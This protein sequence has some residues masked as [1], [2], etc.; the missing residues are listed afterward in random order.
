M[1][2]L[3]KPWDDVGQ[4]C[5]VCSKHM[6]T[7]T[8]DKHSIGLEHVLEMLSSC[9]FCNGKPCAWL[10][11]VALRYTDVQ[12]VCFIAQKGSTWFNCAIGNDMLWST[13]NC[14]KLLGGA[15]IV[16]ISKEASMHV[17]NDHAPFQVAMASVSHRAVSAAKHVD[18]ERW[19]AR[20]W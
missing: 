19:S 4:C 2:R 15:I 18:D 16:I 10:F 7:S 11:P 13:W 12:N 1:C 5:S 8:A 3:A 20:Q 14:L 6:Q 17:P 9:W